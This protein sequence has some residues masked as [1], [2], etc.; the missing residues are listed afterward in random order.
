M[1]NK[2]WCFI[3]A[4]FCL[5]QIKELLGWAPAS[6]TA[7]IVMQIK[8]DSLDFSAKAMPL[9]RKQKEKRK[10]DKERGESKNKEKKT[11]QGMKLNGKVSAGVCLAQAPSKRKRKNQLLYLKHLG[12]HLETSMNK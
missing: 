5:K 9:K 2:W 4:Y 10:R 3:I 12:T 7:K 11:G 8:E 1:R 6:I